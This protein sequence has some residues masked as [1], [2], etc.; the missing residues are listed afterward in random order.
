MMKCHCSPFTFANQKVSGHSC[1][2]QTL[3]HTL[4]TVTVH[5]HFG[6]FHNFKCTYLLIA[7]ILSRKFSHRFAPTCGQ[8]QICGLG[9][10]FTSLYL[11][12]KVAMEL[13]D[14]IHEKN[15]NQGLVDCYYSIVHSS[16]T[17][18]TT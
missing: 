6:N 1:G 10:S 11:C 18:E 3:I 13:N 9:Q 5:G 16:K 15:F 8:R 4:A 12:Q 7:A 17:L 2:Q 14:L